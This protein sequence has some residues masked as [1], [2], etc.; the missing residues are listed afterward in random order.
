M[1]AIPMFGLALILGIRNGIDR[2]HISAIAD[3]VGGKRKSKRGF[4]LATRHALG[5]EQGD[6]DT[7]SIRLP[8]RNVWRIMKETMTAWQGA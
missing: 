2:D 6:H 4:F 3:L 1:S 7:H 8:G 5:H